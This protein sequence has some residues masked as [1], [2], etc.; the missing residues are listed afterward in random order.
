MRLVYAFDEDP[1]RRSRAPRREG[2]RPRGDDRARRPGAGRI[3][4]HDRGL[5]RVHAAR[6]ARPGRARAEI[7]EHVARLEERTGQALRRPGRPAA[8][9]GPLG[10]RDLDA[11]DDGH[12]P[13]P[14]PQRRGGRGARAATGQPPLRVRLVPPADPDVRRGRRRRR[15]RTSSRTSS[16]ALKERARRARRTSSSTPTTCASCRARSRDLRARGRRAVPAGRAR[17]APARDAAPCSTRGVAARAGLPAAP[18]RSRTTSARRSTSSRWS[19]ATRATAPARASLHARP[20][21]GRARASTASSSLNAQGEDVVAGI[22]TPEPI[23]R[24]RGAAAGGLRAARRDAA[25]ARGALPRHAGH[26]VHG[27]GGHAV[28]APDAHRQADGAGGAADRGGDGRTRA[29]SPARRRSRAIDPGQLDQLLHP[30]IDPDA[31]VEV[32]ATGLNASPGAASGAIVLDADRAEERGSAGEAVVLV[33]WETTPDDIH[34]LIQAPRRPDRPRRDDLARGGRRARD[35]E[36]VR[37]RLRGARDRPR[38]RA[39]CTIGDARAARGRPAHDRRRHRTGDRRRRAA[40]AARRSTRTSR[41]SSAGPTTC[42]ACA[43][44]RTPTRRRTPRRR[45]SSAPRASASAAPSTCSWPTDRLPVVREMILAAGREAR[46]AALDRLL[47]SSRRDFEGIFE[48]MAGLPVTIRLLDPPLH[49]FLPS[50]EEATSEA[51]RAPDRAAPRGEPDAR[52]ARLPARPHLP[53]DLRDAGARDRACGARGRASA[54]A[55]RRSSRSCTRSSASREELRRLRELTERVAAEEPTVEYL[56][57]HDDR[58]PARVRPRR[59]DRR[60]TPTSSRSA[61]TTSR[62]PRSASRATTPRASSSRTTSRTASS[63][64]TRSRRSTATGVGELMRIAVERGRGAKPDLKLGICGEHGGDPRRSPSATS[65]GSTTSRCSP[66]R[67]PL[68]RLAAAQAA[69]ADA[70]VSAAAV[71]G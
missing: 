36:A 32:A 7:D 21:H 23:E 63:S 71:G 4:D 53:G 1:P 43:C 10:R 55:R 31:E 64:A 48:A 42:A 26:R 13:Q 54:R 6:R 11:G 15:G 68:A 30:M 33:R 66:F 57:R 18:T 50:L 29:S 19:S 59:R 40:R 35:G 47:P 24:M 62:R 44:A 70:G 61:R 20:V 39:R 60:A 67:V 3:H 5:P 69:L 52:H 28:P 45:A 49:E 27:R 58:A 46:R 2:R 16:Q 38:P 8:R 22:R 9:L 14:R 51:M 65:S 25:P 56:M 17:A 41:R 12:D 37:R 34:G